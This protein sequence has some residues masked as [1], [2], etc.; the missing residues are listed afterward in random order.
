MCCTTVLQQLQH[1]P[2]TANKS[3]RTLKPTAETLLQKH[4]VK[5]HYGVTQDSTPLWR[6]TIHNRRTQQLR[7]SCSHGV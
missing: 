6:A 1:S 3:L 5:S 4:R 7:Q 2:L